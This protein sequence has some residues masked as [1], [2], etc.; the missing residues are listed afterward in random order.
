MVHVRRKFFDIDQAT[1][2]PAAK[3]VLDR[4]GQLYAVEEKV[5]GKPPDQRAA[6]RRAE[7]GPRITELRTVLEDRLGQ[8]SGKSPLAGAI[9]YALTRW[10]KLTRYREDG[11]LE[12]DNNIAERAMRAIATMRS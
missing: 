8:V 11:R 5:R 7:A 12:I 9:R 3:T 10:T 1:K 6:L 4:I 2:G